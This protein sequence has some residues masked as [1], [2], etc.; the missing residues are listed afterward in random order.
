MYSIV[1]INLSYTTYCTLQIVSNE[2]FINNLMTDSPD[3]CKNVKCDTQVGAPPISPWKWTWITD[4]ELCWIVFVCYES[5]YRQMQYC[6]TLHC[7]PARGMPAQ[8]MQQQVF[9]WSNKRQ[10]CRSTRSMYLVQHLLQVFRKHIF[11]WKTKQHTVLD[12]TAVWHY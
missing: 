8:C 1:I 9:H 7:T 2:M 5:Q 10:C 12:I 3:T 11:V 6:I 4:A